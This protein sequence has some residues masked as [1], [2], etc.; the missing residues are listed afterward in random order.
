MLEGL[1]RATCLLELIWREIDARGSVEAGRVRAAEV[2]VIAAQESAPTRATNAGV[3]L[4]Q[5]VAVRATGMPLAL[6]AP[7]A[8]PA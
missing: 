4:T 5:A 8:R 3:R 2:E 6:E 7:L 1:A